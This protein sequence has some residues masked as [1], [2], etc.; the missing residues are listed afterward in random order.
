MPKTR[1]KLDDLLARALER[2]SI[3]AVVAIVSV[4]VEGW[5]DG[6][7]IAAVGAVLIAGRSVVKA[8]R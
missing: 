4:F 5:R 7:V 8:R 3:V 6:G 1:A 2:E